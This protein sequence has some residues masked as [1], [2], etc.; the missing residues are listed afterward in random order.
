MIGRLHQEKGH[1]Y[2]FDALP[3][4][5]EALGPITTVLAGDGVERAALEADVAKRGLGGMVRFVGWR[6][7]IPELITLSSLVVLPSLAE[8]FGFAVLEAMSLGRPVVAAATGGL[9]EIIENEENGLLV[10]AKDPQA[11]ADAM[12][13]VL[14]DKDLAAR[15]AASGR[16]RAAFFS[17]E[18]MM[19]GYESVYEACLAAR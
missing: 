16:R 9:R 13:R 6:R 10:P 12:I 15:L 14:R 3:R 1:R 17:F 8:S 2:L 11:L 5:V 19:S 7:E 4:V 18:R